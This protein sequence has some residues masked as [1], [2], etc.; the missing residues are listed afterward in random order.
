MLKA[1]RIESID[2]WRGL[3]LLIIFIDHVPGNPLAAVTPR[4]FGFSD[5]TEAF[6]FLSGLALAY[7][8][9]P[10]FASGE[11]SRVILRCLRRASQIYGAHI[12]I[13]VTVLIIFGAGYVVTRHTEFLN[14]DNRYL[15]FSNPSASLIG[16]L[17]LG[18]QFGYVNILPVY[19]A[20]LFM[21]PVLMVLLRR[22]IWLGLL[23]SAVLYAAAQSGL[24]LPSW[25][26][27]NTWFLNP[28]A[29]Q[30]M[31]TLGLVT[32]IRCRSEAVPPRSNLLL[33]AAAA[34]VFFALF[35]EMD[36]FGLA[37]GLSGN[38]DAYF[39]ANK[40]LLG[41]GRIGHFL[42]LAYILVELKAVSL[43][44]KFPGAHEISRLGR[45][46]LPIFAAGSI[47][48]ALGQLILDLC[49]TIE[50]HLVFDV[51]GLLI[52][53]LGATSL[54]LLAQFLE[55]RI[56]KSV[57]RAKALPEAGIVLQS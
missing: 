19:V 7:A 47:L 13:S 56:S 31:F 17:T 4:H 9:W 1:H 34:M 46:S 26:W 51:I 32:G 12:A 23:V 52:I 11:T 53:A 55:W 10:K 35:V 5:S 22:R 6:I 43:L 28:F 44:L 38:V 20:I 36:G 54:V 8:Y 41:L 48:S 21:A 40:Q 25:P 39:G 14:D 37:P 29:W 30:F 15:F 57:G 16:L 49:R 3:A 45:H 18:Y 27:P 33:V 50:N 42:A 2:F 24:Q